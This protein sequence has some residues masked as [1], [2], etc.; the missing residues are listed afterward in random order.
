MGI[1]SLR[2]PGIPCCAH[3]LLPP[4][5]FSL[6]SPLLRAIIHPNRP[7]SAYLLSTAVATTIS[8]G[9]LYSTSALRQVTSGSFARSFKPAHSGIADCLSTNHNYYLASNRSAK[10]VFTPCREVS[11]SSL[12]FNTRFSTSAQAKPPECR[13]AQLL[14]TASFGGTTQNI[15]C[16]AD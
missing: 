12:C 13:C 8:R 16:P 4:C 2:L 3:S 1:H 10:Q 11:S 7:G 6:L 9:E 15:R 14:C 5:T